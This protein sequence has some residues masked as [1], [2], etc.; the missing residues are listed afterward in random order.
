MKRSRVPLG[1]GSSEIHDKP[2]TMRVRPSRDITV[3]RILFL[4]TNLGAVSDLRVDGRSVPITPLG[5]IEPFDVAAN[6]VLELEVVPL[7]PKAPPGLGLRALRFIAA[8]TFVGRWLYT[9][10][11]PPFRRVSAACTGW[12]SR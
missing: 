6:A 9:K 2:I 1:F 11:G 4:G 8:Q 7:E 3:D 12:V 10:F 5:E